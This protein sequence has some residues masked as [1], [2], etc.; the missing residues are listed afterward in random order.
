ME[1]LPQC[2]MK[3]AL[4][5]YPYTDPSAFMGTSSTQGHMTGRIEKK[6]HNCQ[7][8]YVKIYFIYKRYGVVPVQT[9]CTWMKKFSG[10]YWKECWNK[11]STNDC[12]Y[13]MYTWLHMH[14]LIIW[15]VWSNY[16]SKFIQKPLHNCIT[17]HKSE[18]RYVFHSI[19]SY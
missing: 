19:I 17:Y 9:P 7:I 5:C 14:D 18:L 8:S 16:I 2:L 13:P 3:K 6:I 4:V 10:S 12:V 15:S 1:I 11:C